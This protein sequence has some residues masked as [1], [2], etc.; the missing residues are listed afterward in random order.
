MAFTEISGASRP[1]SR[2]TACGGKSVSPPTRKIKT[3]KN[4]QRETP[5]VA[6]RKL[7]PKI[8]RGTFAGDV[9]RY[10]AGRTQMPT[11][12]ERAA[13]L[14][15]WCAEFGPRNRHSI[16]T[17][18]IETV[19]SRWLEAGLQPSTVRNRRT[20]LQALW[21]GLDGKAAPNPVREALMPVL[22]QP[23]AR[24]IPYKT[25]AKILDA[26]PNVG[27]GRLGEAREDQSKTK[28]RLAVIAYTGLPHALIKK[29][30]PEAIDGE[31]KLWR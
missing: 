28:A 10:L 4:W 16:E 13:H 14:A 26:M 1:R 27:Q 19:L 30:T 11:Y 21:T 24:A 7:R 8:G 18:E 3:I 29:L 9:E 12:K 23:E 22:A 31:R 17:V 25:I 6:L 15:L 5:R 20:A 2:Q